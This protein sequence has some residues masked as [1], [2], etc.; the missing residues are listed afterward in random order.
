MQTRIEARL[1]EKEQKV[2][3]DRLAAEQSDREDKL[4]EQYLAIA[5]TM[6]AILDAS[7]ARSERKE[8]S[9]CDGGRGSTGFIWA[10]AFPTAL[11]S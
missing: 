8:V 3:N 1:F 2:R 7:I 9:T 5:E 10:G 6:L 11:E 4:R